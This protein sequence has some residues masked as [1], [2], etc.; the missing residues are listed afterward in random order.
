MQ[1]QVAHSLTHS[2]TV[3]VA[4]VVVLLLVSPLPPSKTFTCKVPPKIQGEDTVD[5]MDVLDVHQLIHLQP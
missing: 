1:V 5:A 3:V 2:L 4:V